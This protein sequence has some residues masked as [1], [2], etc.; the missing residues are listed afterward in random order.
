VAG[1]AVERQLEAFMGEA[2]E[3]VTGA[4][5]RDEKE[6]VG[7][8]EVAGSDADHGLD[9]HVAEEVEPETAAGFR[10]QGTDAGITAE[11]VCEKGGIVE[12]GE[13]G[14]IVHG[15]SADG[16]IE[17]DEGSD[18][19]GAAQHIPKGE[20]LVDEAGGF[21][22]QEIAMVRDGAGDVPVTIRGEEAMVLQKRQ[23]VREPQREV[24]FIP[25]VV[26]G[27][28]CF[29]RAETG[30]P[31][32]LP[33]SHRPA[34]GF[35]D[36]GF[37][38]GPLL[39]PMVEV[40]KRDSGENLPGERDLA[41]GDIDGGDIGDGDP[42]LRDLSEDGGLDCELGILLGTMFHPDEEGLVIDIEVPGEV[43]ALAAP[44]AQGEALTGEAFPEH[45]AQPGLDGRGEFGPVRSS[46][47]GGR[48]VTFPV[49]NVLAVG[50]R[51]K[52]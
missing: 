8:L 36:D 7:A 15:I 43:I 6:A 41:A 22:L 27:E 25:G 35:R 50:H 14:K 21:Q 12:T 11:S 28:G 17:V 18:V 51:E 23:M 10:G 9:Q 24:R 45:P 42:G 19:V 38:E 4:A 32:F 40:G 20:I 34:E 3:I 48:P 52:R 1:Q 33:G 31:D 16:V 47:K 5:G 44:R 2:A 26:A 37:V 39:E 30:G 49:V 29:V 13:E 46:V